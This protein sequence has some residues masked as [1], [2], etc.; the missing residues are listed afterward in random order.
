MRGFFGKAAIDSLKHLSFLN[1]Y[2]LTIGVFPINA[3]NEIIAQHLGL[4][5][6]LTKYY[7]DWGNV[8]NKK[9]QTINIRRGS[10]IPS[11]VYV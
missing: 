6:L 9:T 2:D 7:F 4:S 3:I 11:C 1:M 5:R 8:F 10:H